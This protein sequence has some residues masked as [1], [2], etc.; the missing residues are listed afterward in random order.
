M[1][2]YNVHCLL[3]NLAF[4][5]GG[6]KIKAILYFLTSRS[7]SSPTGL[8]SN[9]CRTLARKRNILVLANSSPGHCLLPAPNPRK[10]KQL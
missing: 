3:T 5:G 8:T 6:I 9:F 4:T 7:G 2:Q 1:Y 10:L